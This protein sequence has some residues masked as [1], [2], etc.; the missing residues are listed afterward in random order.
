[1]TSHGEIH[2]KAHSH[3]QELETRAKLE[4]WGDYPREVGLPRRSTHLRLGVR[5]HPGAS[6]PHTRWSQYGTWTTS[7][8][9][10]QSLGA[11]TWGR[12]A[13]SQPPESSWDRGSGVFSSPG[14][15]GNSTR[16][17]QP[18][19][20]SRT[21]SWRAEFSGDWG[22][23]FSGSPVGDGDSI[24]RGKPVSQDSRK[25][26][27]SGGT[28]FTRCWTGGPSVIISRVVNAASQTR[29]HWGRI[30]NAVHGTVIISAGYTENCGGYE[31]D[32]W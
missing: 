4:R 23:R 14:G 28:G 7:Y 27:G 16:R 2:C 20:G 1:M 8:A 6:R 31:M 15:K 3:I 26:T 25:I 13:V 18:D 21:T 29:A 11:G 10:E 32:G 30:T 17:R 9:W 22:L 19:S 12:S 24:Q 5:Y